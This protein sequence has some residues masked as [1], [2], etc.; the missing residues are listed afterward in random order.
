MKRISLL[1]ALPSLLGTAWAGWS[2]STYYWNG[3]EAGGEQ[4]ARVSTADSSGSSPYTMQAGD[5][6]FGTLSLLSLSDGSTLQVIENT[7]NL[8]DLAMLHIEELSIASAG[9]ASLEVG[10]RQG[11]RLDAVSS[12]TLS[13]Q[14]TGELVAGIGV[15]TGTQL[16]G[17]GGVLQ[18]AGSYDAS[19]YTAPGSYTLAEL[20]GDWAAITTE[21]LTL[22]PA[23]GCLVGADV[24]EGVLQLAVFD[25]AA[26]RH[27]QGGVVQG[28]ATAA[29]ADVAY[30]T[31][32]G[33]AVPDASQEW[34]LQVQ[35]TLTG[36]TTSSGAAQTVLISSFDPGNGQVYGNGKVYAGGD[37][38][39]YVTPDGNVYLMGGSGT[40]SFSELLHTGQ[41]WQSAEYQLLLQGDGT[42]VQVLSGSLVLDGTSYA[43]QTGSAALDAMPS[44]GLQELYMRGA[45]GSSATFTA[46]AGQG[47][48][49]TVQQE[50][51]LAGTADLALLRA[52]DYAAV[53]G[54]GAI[55]AALDNTTPLLFNGG[56]LHSASDAYLL[57]S[58][59]ASAGQAIRFDLASGSTLRIADGQAAL[60]SA[61]SGM[62]LTGGGT[63][64]LE[65]LAGGELRQLT[66]GAGSRLELQAPAGVQ[67]DTT[68]NT[69]ATTA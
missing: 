33:S 53:E 45:T 50:W 22:T 28:S 3:D 54:G 4:L 6:R 30:G 44:D 10:V 15:A 35:G 2:G 34:T 57:N 17:N 55:A 66:V 40:G 23:T 69:L 48:A 43:L 49:P 46:V 61:G 58:L 5:L 9:N 41:T 39:L 8:R 36:P 19:A 21:G 65:S 38:A 20:S 47:S 52:G 42:Q 24:S 12:G 16:S 60:N 1:W 56:T 63:L 26:Y 18:L 29:S 7:S 27:L 68:A 37:F 14:V 64:R 31:S 67:L 62:V 25:A 51:V 11:V 13:I 32:L 59:S